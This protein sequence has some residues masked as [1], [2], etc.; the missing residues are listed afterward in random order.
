MAFEDYAQ[1]G[2]CTPCLVPVVPPYSQTDCLAL[3]VVRWKENGP[4][5]Y[6]LML[7]WWGTVI[8]EAAHASDML[9]TQNLGKW[10]LPGILAFCVCLQCRTCGCGM[11]VVLC[12]LVCL[13][14]QPSGQFFALLVFG[15]RSAHQVRQVSMLVSC[16]MS[17]FVRVLKIVLPFILVFQ[18]LFYLSR[19]GIWQVPLLASAPP[20]E[21]PAVC[22]KTC[23]GNKAAKQ[24]HGKIAIAQMNQIWIFTL[25]LS[26]FLYLF[27]QNYDYKR[28]SG[29][30]G[31]IHPLCTG[32]K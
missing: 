16:C 22:T 24:K 30:Q 3:S 2:L 19:A 4:T 26:L 17:A 29:L 31:K 20:L 18:A 10:L 23:Y 21:K 15:K 32:R 8:V 27:F 13:Y 28:V 25:N 11:A 1:R 6:H 7:G 14:T 9:D 12:K 5:K